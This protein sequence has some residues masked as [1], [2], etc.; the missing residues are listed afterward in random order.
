V[1]TLTAAHVEAELIPLIQESF[2]T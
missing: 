1:P 2:S